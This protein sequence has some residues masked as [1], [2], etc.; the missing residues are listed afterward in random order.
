MHYRRLGR[1]ELQVSAVGLGGM[2]FISKNHKTIEDATAIIHRALDLGINFIDSARG[3]WDSEVMLGHV[4]P[5]RRHEMVLATKTYLRS[6]VLAE[7]ELY[8]SLENLKTNKIDLYQIHHVQYDYELEQVLGPKGAL[9]ALELA[10]KEGLID[11]IGITSHHMRLLDRCLE[12]GRFDTVMFPFSPVEK[13]NWHDVY[14]TARK[15]DVGI[16]TMK[17]LAGGRLTSVEDSLKFILSYP[18]STCILGCSTVE[19]VERD[20]AACELWEKL[21]EEEK[22][23]IVEAGDAVSDPF[24]RR[25]RLCEPACPAGIPIADVFRIEDYLI[26]NATYARNE[27]R[28]LPIKATACINC[29]EC[30]VICPWDLEV[31]RDLVRAHRRLSQGL[32]EDA[33]VNLLRKLRL[34]DVARKLYFD[35]GGNLPER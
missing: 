26:L 16:I 35:M 3:Y 21:S 14:E 7:K 15:H 4:I 24:C 11:W 28:A 17:A 8:K 13:D 31:T 18:V 10:R 5:Q 33:A 1:T 19:H 22:K 27:Y 29:G 12:T 2:G 25:C 34:Y 30:E 32:L 6:G 20:V 9:E 23:A